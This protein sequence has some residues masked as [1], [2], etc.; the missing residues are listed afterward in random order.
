MVS[1]LGLG[2]I[3]AASAIVLSILLRPRSSKWQARI[4]AWKL[5]R[6]DQVSDLDRDAVELI[7]HIADQL[8]ENPAKFRNLL[9]GRVQANL[10]LEPSTRTSSSFNAAFQ[11]LGGRVVQISALT[12]SVTK[13]ETLY[14]TV[15]C[16]SCFADVIII[17]QPKTGLALLVPPGEG[18]KPIV[19]A[20]DGTG[21]H[22]TQA[23]LDAYTIRRDLG[24]VRNKQILFIGDLKNGRTVHSLIQMLAFFEGNQFKY[25]SPPTLELQPEFT[26]HYGG[27]KV[28]YLNDAIPTADVMYVT[29]V[30]KER[31]ATDEEYDR[32]CAE[33]GYVINRQLLS[34]AKPNMIVM[35]PLP[36]ITEITTDV[37]SD[38][39]AAYFRQMENG[40]YVR[41]A[42][43]ALIVDNKKLAQYID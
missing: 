12:S 26:N 17:R 18:V 1:R 43:V 9:D 28:R 16:L 41:M 38:P 23:L 6:L 29:R 15:R 34:A 31:F 36:R 37:D 8:R 40:L 24:D 22:P 7:F 35:H 10:F 5:R 33:Y 2:L 19:N 13:G 4:L 14:D 11:R 42:L 25:F 21:E 32:V 30:Q 39:R 3:G 20:G 27:D